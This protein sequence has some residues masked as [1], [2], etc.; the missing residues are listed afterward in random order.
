M[1]IWRISIHAPR[2]G[3]DFLG[4]QRGELV[5]AFQSTPPARGATSSY[6]SMSPLIVISIHAPREGGD[7]RAAGTGCGSPYF[8]PRP[9]RG[10]RHFS[11]CAEIKS[12][13]FQSTPPARGA[14]AYHAFLH[15][16]HTIS[17]HAPREGGDASMVL[18]LPTI[19]ISIHA[20]R[21]G[22]DVIVDR[23]EKFT[24]KFQSTPPARGATTLRTDPRTGGKISIHA[25]R[26]GG[27]ALIFI[28]EHP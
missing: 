27:D 20:P 18:R 14:T 26:E 5:S 15:W 8:N 10:G 24:G 11:L 17:I 21:E 1:R 6:W 19:S 4:Y 7:S 23:W 28:L 16:M 22:G 3:G 2:E 13:T 9:P 12:V 25:P